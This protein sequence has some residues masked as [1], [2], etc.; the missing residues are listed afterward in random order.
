[1]IKFERVQTSAEKLN[2]QGFYYLGR[3]KNALLRIKIFFLS[4]L[5]LIEPTA[6]LNKTL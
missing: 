5:Y 2:A 6:Y 4:L 3:F 1:M